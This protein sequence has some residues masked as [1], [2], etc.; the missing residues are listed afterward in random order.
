M[1][2]KF[3]K[4]INLH[5]FPYRYHL[6]PLLYLDSHINDCTPKQTDSTQNAI[7]K[8]TYVKEKAGRL[9]VIIKQ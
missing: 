4:L 9:Y 6:W 8:A 2:Q 3:S 5:E 1:I 7:Y